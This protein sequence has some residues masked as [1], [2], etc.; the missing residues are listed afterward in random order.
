VRWSEGGVAA[1]DVLRARELGVPRYN[2]FRR[3]LHLKPA[4]SF[5]ALTGGDKALAAEISRVYRDDIEK[6]DLTV[7]M[8]AE[9]CPKGFAF[10]DTAFRIFLLM[11]ARRFSSDR[12]LSEDFNERVYSPSGIEWVQSNTMTSVLLRHYPELAP[13]F[14]GVRNAFQPW[15]KVPAPAG[16]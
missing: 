10:G 8:F 3:L 6:V 5:E 12:F 1:T 4:R 14:R 2:Q 16:E 13:A 15:T 9:P 7:G 11:A